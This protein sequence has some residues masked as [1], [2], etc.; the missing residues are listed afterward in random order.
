[1]RPCVED[2]MTTKKKNIKRSILV[3]KKSKFAIG[4]GRALPFVQ[5]LQLQL[6]NKRTSFL[7]NLMV[8]NDYL[9]LSL[10][11]VKKQQTE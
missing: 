10:H 2:K 7:F 3:W 11:L 8:S 4:M 1:M 9:H 5:A 6:I